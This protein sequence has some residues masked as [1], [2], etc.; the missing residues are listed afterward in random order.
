[1]FVVLLFVSFVALFLSQTVTVRAE[2]KTITVP[3]DYASIQTAID[4]AD[5]GDTILVKKGFYT[6]SLVVDKAVSLIGENSGNTII[7]GSHGAPVIL[8]RHDNVGIC[9]FTLKNGVGGSTIYYRAA[10]AVH[11]LHSN[12]CNVSGNVIVNS[13]IGVWIYGASENIVTCNSISDS[14]YGIIV[15]SSDNNTVTDNVVTNNIGGIRLISAY[16]N[17]LRNNLMRDN[18]RSFSVSGDTL[19]MFVNDVDN[20]NTVNSKPICYWIGVS[21]QTVPTDVA[22]VVLVNCVNMKVHNFNLV[23]AYDGILLAGTHNSTVTNNIIA[24]SGTGIRLFASSNNV[25]TGNT[26]D[27]GTGITADG[28]GTQIANNN[29]KTSSVGIIIDG[30]NH[31]VVENTVESGTV[32]GSCNI[33]CAHGAYHNVTKNVFRG[34]TYVGLVLDASYCL[35]YDNSIPIS[36]TMRVKGNWNVFA[37][38]SFTDYGVTVYGSRNIVC[39]NSFTD[40]PTALGILGNNSIYCAN[41]V[42]NI[43]LAVSIG[44]FEPRIFDNILYNN[45]FINNEELVKNSVNN[46]ANFWDNGFEGN[47]WST[48]NG[49]DSD[50]DG[51]GDSPYPIK[52]E[53]LDYDLKKMVEYVCGQDNHPLMAPANLLDSSSWIYSF[54]VG[55]WNWTKYKVDVVSDSVVSNFSFNPEETLIQFN[56]TSETSSKQN[57]CRI[58]IPKNMLSANRNWLV[59]VDGQSIVPVVN[60]TAEYSYI[61]FTFMHNQNTI[62]IVG[63]D[64]VPEFPLWTPL[65]VMLVA[66]LVVATVYRHILN[67]SNERIKENF[68]SFSSKNCM[69]GEP[70]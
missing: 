66:V 32:G 14:N 26:L 19:S 42:E 70:Q 57:F 65:L 9:S 52:S 61:Y 47:Y 58:T 60:E 39:A 56:V 24:D 64:A 49:T 29:I 16:N 5:D 59:Y 22:C 30:Y 10:T 41:H 63:T 36:G 45:N 40:G 68:L 69:S 8:I 53:H 44:S 2:P 15:E 1:V 18:G 13:G 31:T 62:K 20:S 4:N 17:K 67:K 11:L 6:E 55:V 50:G 28:N 46:K 37:K 33:F 27:C 43:R 7:E 38:N 3:D 12:G 48:Y 23:R 54:D 25:V 51:I 35:F 34:Q 21:N